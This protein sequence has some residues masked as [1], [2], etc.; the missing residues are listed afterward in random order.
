MV[1]HVFLS[2]A[3]VST[4]YPPGIHKSL[5]PARATIIILIKE[6][7]SKAEWRHWIPGWLLWLDCKEC[8]HRQ[9]HT[10]TQT[11]TH[12]L[13]HQ[14]NLIASPPLAYI[15]GLSIAF[16]PFSVFRSVLPLTIVLCI[17][18][19]DF[20]LPTRRKLLTRCSWA[21]RY[22]ISFYCCSGV[23]IYSKLISFLLCLIL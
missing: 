3:S 1:K 8:T 23:Y 6:S 5:S 17:L 16:G 15:G 11:H 18:N 22:L 4:N 21:C 14:T 19:K 2:H 12:T 7:L 9:T 20:I 10:N 13:S